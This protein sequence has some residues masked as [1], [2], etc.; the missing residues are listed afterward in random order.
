M[1]SH[2]C[3]LAAIHPLFLHFVDTFHPSG[4]EPDAFMITI[5]TVPALVL[6]I[7]F[8]LF[9]FLFLY[10]LSLLSIGAIGVL[11]SGRPSVLAYFFIFI[12][13]SYTLSPFRFFPLLND[14]RSLAPQNGLVS[15]RTGEYSSLDHQDTK[16]PRV[17]GDSLQNGVGDCI[18]IL[19]MD[20][21]VFGVLYLLRYFPL[22]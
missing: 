15:R 12:G 14:R 5:P 20:Y 2:Q 8:S 19:C 9:L 4:S 17:L 21:A 3:E 7:P 10:H 11:Y 22:K 18:G 16:T 6:Y 13:E 1:A